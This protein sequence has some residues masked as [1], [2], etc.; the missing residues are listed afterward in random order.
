LASSS[1]ATVTSYEVSMWR[2]L[3]SDLFS[4]IFKALKSILYGLVAFFT[5]CNRH[6]LSIYNHIQEF[7]QRLY[8]P[9]QRSQ[10]VDLTDNRKP[11][12]TLALVRTVKLRWMLFVVENLMLILV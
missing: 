9:C 2:T 11:C 1:E 5:A 12:L 4:Q 3:W 8:R 7:I 6:R 10:Q